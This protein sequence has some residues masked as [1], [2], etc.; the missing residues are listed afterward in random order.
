[1]VKK[2]AIVSFEKL[3]L[4]QKKKLEATFP[5]GY[6]D[7][8]TKVNTPTGEVLDAIF[9]ETEDIIYLVKL[10]KAPSKPVSLDDDSDD[11]D[12]IDDIDVKMDDEEEEDDDS[13]D[14]DEDIDDDEEEDDDED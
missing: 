3:T 6:A 9:W 2:R 5:D 13:Y 8:M 10:Q 4:D 12:D 11:S 7:A 1:M 14:D